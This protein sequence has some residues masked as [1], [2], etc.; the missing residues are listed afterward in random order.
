MRLNLRLLRRFWPY[1]WRRKRVL[2]IDLFCAA[3][4]TAC[5]I[6]LP[7]IVRRITNA[8]VADV[9]A[10]TGKMIF[11]TGGVYLLLRL[12]DAAASYFMASHGHYMG[13]QIETDMRNDMF[14]HLQGLSFSFYD[15]TKIG[16]L[17]SRLT[18]DLFD[19]TEFAHHFPEELCITTIK[20]LACFVI[21]VRMN[22]LM[23]LLVFAIVPLMFFVTQFSRKRMKRTFQDSRRQVGEINSLAED[24][25]SGIRVVKSFGNEEEENQKFRKSNAR[26]FGFKRRGY[27]Y[28]A[29][30]Q[31]ITRLFD[32]LM[33]LTAVCFGAWLLRGKTITVGDFSLVLLMVSTLL[34]SVRR[35]IEFSEQFNRGITG[36]ER[37]AEVMDE[38]TETQH[39][40]GNAELNT[41][42]GEIT[43]AGVS[44]VYPG[45]E[46]YVLRDFNLTIRP[47][48]SV[49][50]VG[51][52]GGGKTTLCNL[53]PR[54]Y[55]V[56]EG[57]VRIDGNDIREL[58]L[59]SLRRCIGV[60][61]QDVYLF[62]GTVRENIAYGTPGAGDAAIREAAELAGAAEFIEALPEGYDTYVG[63]RGVKL[64]GGQKQRIS[65]ARVFLR[66]PPILLLDEATSA[67]DNESERLVQASLERLAKGRTTLT[68]AH[69]LT[70]IRA[71]KQIVVLTEEGVA[72]SGTHAE[73]LASGGL[74]AQMWNM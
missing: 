56:T 12:M 59:Q 21:F 2:F 58:S 26:F 16:Q 60:V 19:V 18:N 22:P 63:E 34:G 30:Y 65:I 1:L 68:I 37:F 14:A 47:G 73:L 31:T 71:A 70:T 11:L 43:F 51:P 6:V 53:I 64:S 32:G 54:F 50:L 36:I 7:L 46:R 25:L 57:A 62:A 24:S 48:E 52:S 69:R 10:L 5:E 44:F 28:M 45:T 3:L 13:A 72:E 17:M 8:A 67:L 35:I 74:Y 23:A 38:L 40:E 41:V 39:T 9:T 29:Q 27:T 15:N 49:A 20:I 42:R 66:N 61:Q 33:Y 55:D 4:T